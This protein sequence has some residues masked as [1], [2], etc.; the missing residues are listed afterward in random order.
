MKRLSSWATAL[1]LLA[2]PISA[3]APIRVVGTGDP[4]PGAEGGFFHEV[5]KPAL[6]GEWIAAAGYSALRT[7]IF[8][9]HRGVGYE[10]ADRETDLPGV[11]AGAYLFFENPA[12]YDIDASGRVLF[13]LPWV[14]FGTGEDGAGVWSWYQGTI[15]AVI[16]GGEVA[17]GS[18]LPFIA[19]RP[20]AGAGG[21]F[22]IGG[23]EGPFGAPTRV[24][25]AWSAAAGPV[26][27]VVGGPAWAALTHPRASTRVIFGGNPVV[28]P[29]GLFSAALDGS[30]LR[31]ELPSEQEYPGAPRAQDSCP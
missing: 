12:Y 21:W 8:A 19:G 20:Y 27:R 22:F 3:Q 26:R 23:N 31:L 6:A 16:L 13:A 14:D 4:I 17:Q 7:G 5:F 1:I 9:W 10:V 2:A 11:P 28:G 30:D 18:D 15:E 29:G 24:I 25:L